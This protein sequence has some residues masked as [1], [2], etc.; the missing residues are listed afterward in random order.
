MA[1]PWGV[2]IVPS[3]VEHTRCMQR[4]VV[5]V[6]GERRE[7]AVPVARRGRSADCGGGWHGERKCDDLR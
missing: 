1:L 4:S 7:T 3:E 6:G 2:A 5:F